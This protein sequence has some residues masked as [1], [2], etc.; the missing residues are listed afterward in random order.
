MTSEATVTSPRSKTKASADALRKR[1]LEHLSVLRI[2][3]GDNDLDE[4]LGRAEKEKLPHLE[5]LDLLIGPQAAGRLDRSIERRIRAAHFRERK[6]LETF[7]WDFNKKSIDRVEIEQLATGDFIGRKDNLVVVGQSGVG[8]SHIIQALGMR[9]CAIGYRVRYVTSA[10]LISELNASLADKSYLRKIREFV[11]PELLIIDEFGF[12]RIEREE[13]SRATHLL[14]KVIDARSGRQSTALV[15]NIDF[16]T[17]GEYLGDPPL[18]MAFLDRIVD[19]AIILKISGR[20]YR[21]ARKKNG[22]ESK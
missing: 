13:C 17:W 4:V 6:A 12:E 9:A 16:E 3:V 8:K 22:T 7:D 2:P 1:V 20:S 19:G 5:F 10:D 11:R 14:Y 18:A 15:T 21:V